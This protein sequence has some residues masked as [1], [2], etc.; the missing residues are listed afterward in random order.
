MVVIAGRD[1]IIIKKDI[2]D[3][4]RNIPVST[5]NQWLLG[6]YWQGQYYKELCLPF[7]LQ[8]A[9]FLFNMF[10]KAFHWILQSYL[11]IPHLQHFLDDFIFMVPLNLA[12]DAYI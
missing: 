6:F 3:A 10:A 8:T 11:L 2:K 4:F 12:S 7:G 9:P 5:I 1:C